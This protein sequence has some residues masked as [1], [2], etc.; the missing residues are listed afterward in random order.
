MPEVV[1]VQ[2]K[3]HN[4]DPHLKSCAILSNTTSN[5][6]TSSSST[7]CSIAA[8]LVLL[9]SVLVVV[10]VGSDD[11]VNSLGCSLTTVS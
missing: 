10:L 8:L 11:R 9:V 7:S 5:A 4:Y 1:K 2:V 3:H 6:L